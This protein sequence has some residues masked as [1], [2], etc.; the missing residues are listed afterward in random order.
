MDWTT[1]G[2]WLKGNGGSLLGLAGAVATGNIPAGVAAVASMVTEATGESSPAAALARL[3]ADPATM[4]RL[5][6]IAKRDEADIRA[7]HRELLRLE[8][9]DRQ[10]EHEQQQETIR[11]G[12]NAEDEYVRRTRPM[13]A[14]QSWY[15]TMAYILAFELLKA[16]EV[17]KSGAEVEL[18]MI[19]LAPAGAYI[20]FR[21]WDKLRVPRAK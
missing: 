7:H 11:S 9:E 12:D 16:F 1:V 19:L 13:M 5:E 10:K 14:R 3:Q 17:V 6:E 15:A 21:T 18:A 4:V 20:G 8:L 2:A